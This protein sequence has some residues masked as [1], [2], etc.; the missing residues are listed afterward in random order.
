MGNLKAC[1]SHKSD[2]W[3]TPS[4]IYNSFINVGFIDP[5]PFHADFDGLKRVYDNKSIF[6]NPPYSQISIW[7]DYLLD[8]FDNH[9]CDFVL[10]VPARTDTKWFHKLLA[11]REFDI[12]FYKGRLHFNDSK[13]GA[14]FPS[15][16]IMF[17]H[18]AIEIY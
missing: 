17:Y 11:R 16:L 15:I 9:G 8:L 14:P 18:C 3:K 13:Q 4:D 1:F 10:L 6:C 7:V 5:C 12:K 2:H